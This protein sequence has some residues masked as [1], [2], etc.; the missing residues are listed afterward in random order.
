LFFWFG[1]VTLIESSQLLLQRIDA[2]KRTSQLG[3]DGRALTQA[4]SAAESDMSD[5]PR[6]STPGIRISPIAAYVQRT[7]K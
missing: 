7:E 4:A 5:A 3:F 6:T 2:A 1:L